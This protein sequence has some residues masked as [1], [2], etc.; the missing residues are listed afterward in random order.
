MNKIIKLLFLIIVCE[1]VGFLGTIFTFPSISTWYVTLNKPA[2]NPPNWIF[3]PVWTALYFLMGVALFLVLQKKL[4]KQRNSLLI[5]FAVQLFLNFFWSVIFFGF[6]LP[7]AALLEIALL[8]IS[9]TLLVIDFWKFS[10]SA[11]ILLIP[12]LCWVSF[13]AILNLFV[14]LLNP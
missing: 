2:F 5:L 11:A 3:G 9:I 4:K 14:V 8:W 12:Y 6:H 13:A 1:G 10:K 7:L